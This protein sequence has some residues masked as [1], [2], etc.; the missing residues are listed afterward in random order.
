[1][2]VQREFL[3]ASGEEL[4]VIEGIMFP[5]APRWEIARYVQ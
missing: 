1:L 3:I 4:A 5:F 2:I